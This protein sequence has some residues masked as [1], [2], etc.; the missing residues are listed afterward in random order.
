MVEYLVVIIVPCS[1]IMFVD[2]K[3][4]GAVVLN[5]SRRAL[6]RRLCSSLLSSDC[7]SSH[8]LHLSFW[9]GGAFVLNSLHPRSKLPSSG[10][11]DT[12]LEPLSLL[13]FRF[14]TPETT[15]SKA[16]CPLL[17]GGSFCTCRHRCACVFGA[18]CTALAMSSHIFWAW[19]PTLAACPVLVASLSFGQHCGWF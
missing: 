9:E 15:E 12:H 2:G 6:F 19:S 16:L 14:P 17:L 7:G 10:G 3:P 4:S 8:A 18:R 13:G 1:P 5:S 11:R